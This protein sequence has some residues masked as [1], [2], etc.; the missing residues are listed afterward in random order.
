MEGNKQPVWI[1]AN[2]K[3]MRQIMDSIDKTQRAKIT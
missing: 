3:E 1:L 2:T